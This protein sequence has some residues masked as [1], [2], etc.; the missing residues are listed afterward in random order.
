LQV[1]LDKLC[2]ADRQYVE[3]RLKQLAEENPFKPVPAEADSPS[4]GRPMTTTPAARPGRP[5]MAPPTAPPGSAALP[6]DRQATAGAAPVVQ[7]DWSAATMA[8]MPPDGPW[9]LDVGPAPAASDA[10]ARLRALPVP[11]KVDFFEKTKGLVVNAP[12]SH[13]LVG[14][15][16]DN[17][18]PGSGRVVLGD[19]R[20][21][22]LLG[23]F[24]AAGPITPLALSDEGDRALI[25]I[26]EFGFGNS[27]RLELW[28]LASDGLRKAWS[29]APYGDMEGGDRDVKWA[30]FLGPD[31]FATLGGKGKLVVWDLEP[32]KPRTIVAVDENCT[33]GLSPDG[34]FLAFGD[35]GNVGVLEVESGRIAALQTIPSQHVAWPSLGFSPSG[36]K[37]ACTSGSKLY[38]WNT[39]DGSGLPEILLAPVAAGPGAATIWTD[40][41]HVLIAERTLVDVASQVKMWQYGGA[42]AVVGD[43]AG[44]CWFLLRMSPKQ[45]GAVVP[46]K[47]PQPAAVET[48]KRALA[49]PNYFALR[50]GATVSIDAN[51]IPDASRR[52]AVV[53]SLTDRLA[54]VEVKVAAGS[55]LVLSATV[56][57]GKERK[58]SYRSFGPGMRT[59]DFTIRPQI[60][61]VKLT[62]QGQVAWEASASTLPMMDFAHLGP[63]ETLAD[64]VK[65]FEQPNYGFFENL[66]IPR[67]VARPRP[68]GGPVTAL[69]TSQ[70]SATGVR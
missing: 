55:P 34:R 65:K 3:A 60:S 35:K 19:L 23:Q 31:R 12:A 1:D 15:S 11:P 67:L 7:P 21:G 56:T 17:P 28:E 51:A 38:V 26:D 22:K 43:R 41:E 8:E 29:I 70:I 49:D 53:Q 40:E 5:A 69:G 54:Q 46:A 68:G 50:P 36:K 14:F 32:V 10:D 66:E 24:R 63:N 48:L 44:V 27:Y 13:A 20:S 59:D 25:R 64:H 37:L 18:R 16:V 4:P 61:G 6:F 47:L 62:Y 9:S 58:I 42:E 30:R 52:A 39:D 45:A 57:P 2:S 33:P